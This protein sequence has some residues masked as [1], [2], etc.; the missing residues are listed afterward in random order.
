MRPEVFF[1]AC[2]GKKKKIPARSQPS[3]SPFS[4]LVFSHYVPQYRMQSEAAQSGSFFS[5]IF[6]VTDSMTSPTFRNALRQ[7]TIII[8]NEVKKTKK[9]VAYLLHNS[10]NIFMDYNKTKRS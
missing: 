9:V 1:C 10:R 5:K 6:V 3:P 7:Y 4:V 2:A 8:M